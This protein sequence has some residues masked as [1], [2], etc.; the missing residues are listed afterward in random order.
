MKLTRDKVFRKL[1]KIYEWD[2]ELPDNSE[3]YLTYINCLCDELE[4]T[5]CPAGIVHGGLS[6]SSNIELAKALTVIRTVA[7]FNITST[8]K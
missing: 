7:K 3:N 5:I 4:E 2:S 6:E 8:D 1:E